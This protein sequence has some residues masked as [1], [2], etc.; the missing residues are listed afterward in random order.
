MTEPD[1]QQEDLKTPFSFK[2]MVVLV[3]LYLG[4]R[5]VQGVVWVWQQIT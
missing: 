4:W 3:V 2:L 1:R 5:L